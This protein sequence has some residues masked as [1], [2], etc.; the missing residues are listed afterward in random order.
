MECQYVVYGVDN[1]S[2]IFSREKH[3]SQCIIHFDWFSFW[4]LIICARVEFVIYSWI[5][6][7]PGSL[8]TASINIW[9][10]KIHSR[11]PCLIVIACW[12]G[13]HKNNVTLWTRCN[14]WPSALATICP[15]PRATLGGRRRKGLLSLADRTVIHTL[16]NI[17][18]P[19]FDFCLTF[20]WQLAL[21]CCA[22]IYDRRYFYFHSARSLFAFE[23]KLSGLWGFVCSWKNLC[24]IVLLAHVHGESTCKRNISISTYK[25]EKGK[26]Q[27]CWVGKLISWTGKLEASSKFKSR[28]KM[29]KLFLCIQKMFLKN[30]STFKNFKRT[31]SKKNFNAMFIWPRLKNSRIADVL[32]LLVIDPL[33]AKSADWNFLL[34]MYMN[35]QQAIKMPLKCS[36]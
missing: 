8:Y 17:P 30:C 21:P 33:L 7:F 27:A 9:I 4:N 16:F 25:S 28:K 15:S 26:H 20:F 29:E 36:W 5:V 2:A 6:A 23:S 31:F 18:S 32:E 11:M 19:P 3:F 24:F 10:I 1:K 12:L 22:T 14:R 13:L 35:S 34:L